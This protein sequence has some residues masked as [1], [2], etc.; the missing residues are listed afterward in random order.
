MR[1]IRSLGIVA[2]MLIWSCSCRDQKDS[3]E[4]ALDAGREFVRG[5]LDGDY[6]KAETYLLKDSVN[7][8]LFRKQQI[9][10]QTLS[11]E[12]KRKNRESSIRPLSITPTND[13][14]TL[15]RYYHSANP[16]DT[17]TLRIIRQEGHWLVDLKSILK[18]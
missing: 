9:N 16:S 14:T 12:Q 10:D 13:S 6:I 11:E 8:D 7:L 3:A 1:K 17:T 15:F 2:A 4:N 5:V 18:P